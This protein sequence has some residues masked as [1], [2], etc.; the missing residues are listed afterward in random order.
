MKNK[1][2]VL[3]IVLAGI[4]SLSVL[5]PVVSAADKVTI[6]LWVLND[7]DKMYE[8]LIRDFVAENPNIEIKISTRT[9]DGHKEG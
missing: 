8:P 7:Q 5:V 6:E 9:T 4:L 2:L 3:A 1:C